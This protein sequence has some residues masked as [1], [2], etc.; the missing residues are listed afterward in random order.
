MGFNSAFKGLEN[1]VNEAEANL[2]NRREGDR[3]AQRIY[4]QATVYGVL[5]DEGSPRNAL[6]MCPSSP[7]CARSATNF[8][9][10]RD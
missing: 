5:F 2:R 7:S 3:L 9:G 10:R 1:D 8:A 6:V 4:L